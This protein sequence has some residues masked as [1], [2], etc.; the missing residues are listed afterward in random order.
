MTLNEHLPPGVLMAYAESGR[1]ETRRVPDHV[2]ACESC[3]GMLEALAPTAESGRLAE[4]IPDHVYT[5]TCCPETPDATAQFLMKFMRSGVAGETLLPFFRHMN[6]CYDC[7]ELFIVNW[8]AYCDQ[9]NGAV[10]DHR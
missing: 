6:D 9:K 1:G 8:S 2:R 3:S 10:P 4:R 5:E 7:F